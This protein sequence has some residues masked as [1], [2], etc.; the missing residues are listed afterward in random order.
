M[1]SGTV[2]I[3]DIF[4]YHQTGFDTNGKVM[5]EFRATGM[6]PQFYE[7]LRNQGIEVDMSIFS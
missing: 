1:E 6:V 3:N 4:L 5:G 2:Q 7:K